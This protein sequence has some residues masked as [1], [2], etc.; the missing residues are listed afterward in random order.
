[1]DITHCF[2]IERS[3]SPPSYV[4]AD[5]LQALEGPE[6]DIID[7]ESWGTIKIPN[8]SPSPPSTGFLSVTDTDN[9]TVDGST[10]DMASSR[11]AIL[12]AH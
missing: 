11:E 9:A 12:Q 1:M 3:N 7:G 8:S 5:S 4:L 6:E 10:I 2:R